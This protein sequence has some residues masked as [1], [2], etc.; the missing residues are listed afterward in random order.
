MHELG[1]ANTILETIG[2]E[3]RRHPGARVSKAGLR[4]GELAGVDPEALRFCLE[5]LAKGTE[6][7]SLAFEIEPVRQRRACRACGRGVTVEAFR[8]ECPGC[9]SA[10]TSF[11]GGDEL[12]IAYLEVETS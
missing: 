7:E 6:W 10:E 9:G 4:V 2:A 11:A 8:P 3:A 12:E 1:I 5:A